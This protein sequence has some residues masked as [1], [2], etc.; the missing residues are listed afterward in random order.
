[1]S[2]K[3]SEKNLS[4]MP[5]LTLTLIFM[6]MFALISVFELVQQVLEP[7][8]T[9][10]GSRFITIIVASACAVFIAFFPLRALR[11]TETKFKAIY[12][13]SHDAILLLDEN[14]LL[15][16]NRQALQMFG[17][18]DVGELRKSTPAGLSP[19]VKPG[20]PGFRATLCDHIGTEY[21]NGF[22]RFE[23]DFLRRN[24]DRFTA[25][26][27]V[28]SFTRGNRRLLQAAIR[29]ISA[30]KQAEAALKES[31]ERFFSYIRE[32]ALRLKIPVE[33]V[34]ENIAA[35]IT[36]IEDGDTDRKNLLL[37]LHLQEKNLAQIRQ[38]I[39]AMNQRIIDHFGDLT[40][41]S[42]QLLM[43]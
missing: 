37:E 8:L 35:M 30:Q 1:M 14:T 24:G 27:V 32:T 23:G 40:P 13:D 43:E 18:P 17:I 6:G 39:L 12:E 10:W 25:D 41:A 36:E 21:Q 42:K 33:V 19:R 22:T 20:A 31:N 38:N 15:D 29:D 2:K 26:V 7:A 16:C 5:T 34:H 3:I 9:P 11:D 28:S 4:E